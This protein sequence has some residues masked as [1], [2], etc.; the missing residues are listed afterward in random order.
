MQR[1]TFIRST[2]ASAAS[3]PLQAL[4][5]RVE[6]G[7]GRVETPDYGPLE[8]VADQATGL[9]LLL[10]PAGFSYVSF[11]W[12]GDA[13]MN[14]SPTPGAHDGMAAFEG[15]N[16]I[17]RLVRN[18]EQGRG[19]P[20]SSVR[21]DAGA[22]GGT[23]TVEF[24]GVTGQYVNTQDSLSGTIRNCAGGPTPWGSWLTCEET[25]DFTT[26]PHGYVFDVPADGYGDPAP[27]R[28]M[29]RFS[30]E[31]LAVDPASNTVYLTED[32]GTSSGF[33]KYVPDDPTD[34]AAGGRLYMFK[35]MGAWQQNLFTGYPNNSFFGGE[36]VEIDTPDNTSSSSPG[37]WVSSQGRAKGAAH[38]GRL[39]GCWY[40]PKGHVYFVSTS[41]GAV[42]QGQIWQYHLAK[43]WLRLV[44][45]SPSS[46]VLNAPDNLT[47]SPRGGL[48]LCEDGGGTEYVHGLTK[49]GEIFKFAQNNVVLNGE[50]NGI[51]GNFTGSEFAGACYSPDGKWLFFNIQSPGI[52]FAV[53]GPWQDGAL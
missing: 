10:L 51:I 32:A 2:V 48:V 18:H 19:T 15:S 44:F 6:A 27:I 4:L 11:G 9:P 31:A 29:G 43:G 53:T 12:T 5:S 16:G 24:N 49:F 46:S 36:W 47:V 30:H 34:V 21:Y 17:I 22:S 42:G 13:M 40:D 20:F 8:P 33:Y 23:T 26:M 35:V 41:G 37:N 14:G 39:E 28:D 1:R 7:G 3:I 52:T 45:E 38:F 25:N 50:R